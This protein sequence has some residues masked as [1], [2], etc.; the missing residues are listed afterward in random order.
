MADQD[1]IKRRLLRAGL[2]LTDE[3]IDTV[4]EENA[5]DL[6]G[7]QHWL[8]SVHDDDIKEKFGAQEASLE[9]DFGTGDG[10]GDRNSS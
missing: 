4:L 8:E 9:A 10:N 5:D 3:E 1:A 7:F 2:G 6:D